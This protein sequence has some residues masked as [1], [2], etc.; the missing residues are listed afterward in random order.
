MLAWFS[1]NLVNIGLVVVL[2]LITGLLLY[3]VIHD[4]KKGK[5]S[6]GGNCSAC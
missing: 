6:C 3:S 2:A 1:A 5:N 4:K